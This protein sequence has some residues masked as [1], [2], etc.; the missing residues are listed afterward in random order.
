MLV[1]SALDPLR[2]RALDHVREVFGTAPV[3]VEGLFKDD[4]DFERKACALSPYAKLGRGGV[5]CATGH[6]RMLVEFLR[7]GSP[8]A[9]LL[10]DD[11]ILEQPAEAFYKVFSDLETQLPGKWDWVHFRAA[12][13]QSHGSLKPFPEGDARHLVVGECVRVEALPWGSWCYGVSRK[14]ALTLL[15]RTIPLRYAFDCYTRYCHRDYGF[16]G[17][18]LARHDYSIIGSDR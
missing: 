3:A 15:L 2:L 7:S 11:A 6:Q 17:P 12:G 4:P 16:Q 18:T 14:G 9:L 5:A 13:N 1:C 8:Y 10:E